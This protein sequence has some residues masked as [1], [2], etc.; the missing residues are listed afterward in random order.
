MP[1]NDPLFGNPLERDFFFFLYRIIRRINGNIRKRHWLEAI[2][3]LEYFFVAIFQMR[4]IRTDHM[5]CSRTFIRYKKLLQHVW[6]NVNFLLIQIGWIIWSEQ[7][8]GVFPQLKI[9][10]WCLSFVMEI[11]NKISLQN[12]VSIISSGLFASNNRIN[13]YVIID[14]CFGLNPPCLPPS[15]YLCNFSSLTTFSKNNGSP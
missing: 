2:V 11:L 3:L 15:T 10:S 12:F 14:I 5:P 9:K 1:S 8:P 6:F 4:T 13:A 7:P